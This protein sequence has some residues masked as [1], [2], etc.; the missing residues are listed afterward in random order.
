M[1]PFY[2]QTLLTGAPTQSIAK[3][4]VIDKLKQ[5]ASSFRRPT[6]LNNSF[7]SK[8]NSHTLISNIFAFPIVIPSLMPINKFFRQFI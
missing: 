3:K 4:L 6:H 7:F 1:A 8:A 2:Y 5:Y